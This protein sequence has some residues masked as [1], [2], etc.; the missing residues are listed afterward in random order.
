MSSALRVIQEHCELSL[1]NQQEETAG[2]KA[3]PNRKAPTLRC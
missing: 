1:Q 2:T 3:T